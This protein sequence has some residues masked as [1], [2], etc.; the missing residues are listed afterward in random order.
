MGTW[1]TSHWKK[2]SYVIERSAII[3]CD[4]FAY[5]FPTTQ[6]D[7]RGCIYK[8]VVLR[9]SLNKRRSNNDIIYLK[10]VNLFQL[11]DAT[12]SVCVCERESP[13]SICSVSNINIMPPHER[14]TV[15]IRYVI[16][17]I[18]LKKCVHE[19]DWPNRKWTWWNSISKSFNDCST[20]QLEFVDICNERHLKQCELLQLPNQCLEKKIIGC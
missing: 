13:C 12:S 4:R 7:C 16:V 5:F 6:D 11:E 20:L 17:A 3:Q 8:L 1:Y 18:W 9:N 10:L 15:T 14:S 2:K 19:R